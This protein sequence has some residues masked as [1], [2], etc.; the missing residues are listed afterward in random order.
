MH[1]NGR[2]VKVWIKKEDRI[3]DKDNRCLIFKT[4]RIMMRKQGLD[5]RAWGKESAQ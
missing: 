5:C 2:H 1:L 3:K 4:R